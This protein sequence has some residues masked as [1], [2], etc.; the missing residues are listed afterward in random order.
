MVCP[1]CKKGKCT[2]KCNESGGKKSKKS[3][4]GKKDKKKRK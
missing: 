2:G 4:K 3:K 1:L